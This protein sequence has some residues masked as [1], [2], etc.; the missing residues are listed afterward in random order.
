MNNALESIKKSYKPYRLTKK[1]NITIID[2][3]SGSFVIKEKSNSKVRDAYNYLISRNFDY[4]PMLA[5]ETR[6]DVNVFEYIEEI[7][8][9]KEQKALDMIELVALL[10][11]K[12]TYFKEI[13]EDKYKE[14]YENLKSNILYTKN[15]YDN[16]YNIIVEEIYMSPSH[17]LLFRNV[18]KIFT[19]LDFCNDELDNWYDN[20]KN[21]LKSR[22]AYIH[23]N[24]ETDHFIR[25]K[26]GYLISWEKSKI[27]SPIL[28]LINFY[29]KEYMNLNFETIFE[30]YLSS[31]PLNDNEKK[32][33]F[34]VLSIPPVIYLDGNELKV[35]EN[36]RKKL[37]YI[38]KTEKLVKKFI[39]TNE[40]I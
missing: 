14:I 8:M 36:I 16:L 9:P 35:V 25:N 21:D 5:S 13:T 20:T 3:T 19:A 2:S 22:V 33:L 1:K 10:H 39:I 28:D 4:F 11:N 27:D 17:Y 6:D 12:T 34:I 30:K 26:K 40:D 29:Q 31:Y 38:F 7:D 32:L 37:D 24:L 23:N 15:Y 18:Y